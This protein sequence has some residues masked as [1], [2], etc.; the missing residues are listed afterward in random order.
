VLMLTGLLGENIFSDII[1]T[2]VGRFRM[3]VTTV[4]L[5]SLSQGWIVA[6]VQFVLTVFQ[7]PVHNIMRRTL[8]NL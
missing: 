8:G 1:I 6:Q 2:E 7:F 5:R 3:N 4:S